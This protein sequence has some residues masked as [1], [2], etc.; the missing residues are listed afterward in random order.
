[1][2]PLFQISALLALLALVPACADKPVDE[3]TEKKETPRL[4]GRVSS[5]PA[6]R[7]F[8]L[9]QAYGK[10][11]IATAAILTTQGPEGRAANLRVTGEKLGQ[12]AAADIQSGNLEIGDGVYTTV[13][14]PDP[15]PVENTEP[16]ESVTIKR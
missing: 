15:K 7:K 2:N 12:F 3:P 16:A 6:D 1:M 5:I 14:I 11:D 13:P 8:I 4:V 9:I 10:W